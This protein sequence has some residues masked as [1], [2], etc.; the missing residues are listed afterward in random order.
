MK[1]NMQKLE[2]F[3]TVSNHQNDWDYRLSYMLPRIWERMKRTD[4][5]SLR[6]GESAELC[7]NAKNFGI[8]FVIFDNLANEVVAICQ[9]GCKN[10]YNYKF[11]NMLVSDNYDEK[12]RLIMYRQYD[13]IEV[14][15]FE[16]VFDYL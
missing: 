3:L 11:E 9:E 2:R 6:T 5:H 4:D 12:G 7:E 8:W 14:G 13:I 10:Y 16:N 1:I 15:N